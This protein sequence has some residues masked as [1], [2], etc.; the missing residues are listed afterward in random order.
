MQEKNYRQISVISKIVEKIV[1][2]RLVEFW[3]SR[4]VFNQNPLYPNCC[5]ATMTGQRLETIQKQLMLFLWTSAKHL[6]ACRMND[7]YT[8]WNSTGLAGL[9]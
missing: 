3:L 4:K 8:S 9:Y 2:D 6:T 5:Y 7:Y 1:R